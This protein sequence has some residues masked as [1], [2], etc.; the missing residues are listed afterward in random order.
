MS[1][2]YDEYIVNH[3]KNVKQAFDWLSS[4]DLVN[5]EQYLETSKCILKH[6]DSKYDLDEYNAYDEYFYGRN[7]SYQVA[8]DFELAFLRHMHHNPHH[9][10]YWILI[11]DHGEDHAEVIFEMPYKYAIEMIC[12]WW[13]FSWKSNNMY[14]IFDWYEQR[15]TQMRIHADTKKLIED[16][17]KNIKDILDSLKEGGD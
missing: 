1:V 12:D 13:S 5:P 6:D 7:A 16:T 15:K 9:W 14:Q 17:L 10:Q 8:Q 4:Y 2:L 11:N 3:K